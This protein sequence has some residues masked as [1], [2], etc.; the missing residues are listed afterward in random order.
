MLQVWQGGVNIV[1][2]SDYSLV[3]R[4]TPSSYLLTY[5]HI[6]K[7][8]AQEML[9]SWDSLS[10]GS[11]LQYLDVEAANAVVSAVAISTYYKPPEMALN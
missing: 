11:S 2:V 8:R 3:A 9:K 4:K 6:Y 7:S 10:I 5:L 1:N